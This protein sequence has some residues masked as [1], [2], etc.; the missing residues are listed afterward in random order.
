MKPENF[1][2]PLVWPFKW[3]LF[4]RQ[5]YYVKVFEFSQHVIRNASRILFSA[6]LRCKQTQHQ[7]D[8]F[9]KN[10]WKVG[11][12]NKAYFADR[13]ELSA[14]KRNVW[15][16]LKNCYLFAVCFG[17][18]AAKFAERFYSDKVFSP[19][20]LMSLRTPREQNND[21]LYFYSCTLTNYLSLY[22]IY[23]FIFFTS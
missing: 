21:L 17:R 10:F 16:W 8:N 13:K 1:L 2:I 14:I 15:G 6:T 9:F 23:S 18:K 20:I 7:T 11:K 19:K 4:N 12:R 22:S 5:C 3:N